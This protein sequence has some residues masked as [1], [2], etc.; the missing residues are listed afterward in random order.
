MQ[1]IAGRQIPLIVV[2][3]GLLVIGTIIVFLAWANFNVFSSYLLEEK[4]SFEFPHNHLK[5]HRVTDMLSS[6]TSMAFVDNNSILVLERSGKVRLISDG[7]LRDQPVLTLPVNTEGE[8]GLLGIATFVQNKSGSYPMNG[9]TEAASGYNKQGSN[10]VFLYFT[11]SQDNEPLR[12]RIYRYEW[13]G[14]ELT[15]PVLMLDLPAMPGPYHDGGKL[16]V[17]PDNYLYAVIG[18]LNS[19]AG[20][21]Q[22]L[23]A[24]EGQH[25]DT[26]VIL[27]IP[28][29][30]ASD[31]IVLPPHDYYN[32][33]N[34]QY[35]LAYGI[36]NSFGLTF[37]PLTGNLWDTENGEDK[38]DEINLV[39]PG[40][41]SGWYKVMG[42]IL[43]SNLTTD[44]LVKFNG[45]TYSDPEF[46]WHMP[47]G[48]TD[49]E[50]FSSD[51]LGDGYKNNI[52]VG[53]I[54]GGKMYFF[55]LNENRT[56]LQLN[57]AQ[58]RFSALS[59]LV[60]DSED[61]V[62]KVTFGKGFDRIT[63]IETGPDGL[64]YVLSYESGRIYKIT[65]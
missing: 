64:L 10:F 12:N 40:F 32:T 37:D 59:D 30:N 50:F 57:G 23:G 2:V 27:R 55:R 17:G 39:E 16:E 36:R 46:S 56:G 61:E 9:N 18:D 52:F 49:I 6:P 51:R 48:V 25:Y 54:N 22:N 11:E 45:S 62:S 44:E 35:Y 1:P 65:S 42:P 33:K 28:L 31:K 34:S 20:P 19:V 53:D 60:A 14:R 8:R 43:R 4:P 26:S 47:I 21:L 29:E 3:F 38:Y 24:T 13:N 15:N 5:V 63:D 58:D 41:N 7:I